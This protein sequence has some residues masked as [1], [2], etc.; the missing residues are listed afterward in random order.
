MSFQMAI[1]TKAL[2]G[3]GKLNDLHLQSMPGKKALLV[4]S[5]G[6]STKANGYLAR[7]EK[8]LQ[9]A[10]VESVLFDQIEANPLKSTVMRGAQTARQNGCDFIVALGGGSCMDAA[11]AIAVMAVNEGDLW[12]YITQGT[13]KGK[14]IA[15]KPLPI[16]A[17]TTTAGTGSETDAGGV[18]TNEETNEKTAIKGP[19]LFPVLAIIDPELMAT[20]PPKFTAYQGFD[21]LF[22]NIEGYLSN[23]AN[24]MSEM[25]A[26]EAVRQIS[27]Y[28]PIAVH[29][30]DNMEA[31]ERVAFGNYLGGLEMCLS[32][33]MSEHSLE[34]AL[35]AYHQALP[36]GAGLI[37]LSRAYFS[38][39]ITH[40]VCDERFVALAKKMGRPHATKAEDFLELLVELQKKCGVDDLKMSDYGIQPD[41]FPKMAH[42]A[43][44]AMAGLF[45]SDR[46][47]LSEADCVSIL[48][49]AYR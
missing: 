7:T 26:L 31:R 8:E 38:Y 36:H 35:S 10:G 44:T 15:V 5:N 28:L 34:H 40:H 6:K 22:H 3:A 30:G 9:Q 39:M 43:K 11:K 29:H 32:S 48:Q 45:K 2:F 4:I 16:I 13:G 46:M 37:M 23:K 24:L 20:V 14:P 12:D 19:S 1:P 49:A 41:E 42:N 47:D 25:V 21:A 18:I 27:T 17:I 33:N